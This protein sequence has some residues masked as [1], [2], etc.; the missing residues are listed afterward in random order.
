MFKKIFALQHITALL[1]LVNMPSTRNSFI[2]TKGIC[3]NTFVR[4]AIIYEATA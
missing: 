4:L 1:N 3:T 2:F